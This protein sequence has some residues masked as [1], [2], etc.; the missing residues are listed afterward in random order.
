[1]NSHVPSD[2]CSQNTE[3]LETARTTIALPCDFTHAH[4]GGAR[5]GENHGILFENYVYYFGDTGRTRQD[6]CLSDRG[7]ASI[8]R[9]QIPPRHMTPWPLCP[10]FP[11]PE[12]L[13]HAGPQSGP[14]APRLHRHTL[15]TKG[16]TLDRRI[17]QLRT[18]IWAETGHHLG[19]VPRSDSR[20]TNRRP[21]CCRMSGDDGKRVERDEGGERSSNNGI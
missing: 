17:H 13:P 16:R 8:P 3:S 9:V 7:S 19:I 20:P 6:K 15:A 21:L 5:G 18:W 10:S 12:A 4:L 11:Y 14:E 2:R 1:M